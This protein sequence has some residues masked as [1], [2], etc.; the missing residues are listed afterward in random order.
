M[1]YCWSACTQ[2]FCIRP[3]LGNLFRK[4]EPT[5]VEIRVAA[6]SKLTPSAAALSRSIVRLSCEP[7]PSPVMRTCDSTGLLAA[8]PISSAVAAPSA[9]VPAPPR[10]CRRK[11]KPE[12]LP[13]DEIAGGT[14]VNTCA[15]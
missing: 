4:A 10:S 3:M 9:S 1:R 7:G 14:R 6:S 2:M 8:M 5:A 11:S 15:S 12:A 13:S